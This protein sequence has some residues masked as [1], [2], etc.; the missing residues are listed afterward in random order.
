[1]RCVEGY[2]Y[3]GDVLW[4]RCAKKLPKWYDKGKKDGD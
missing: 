2:K 3:V 4:L 1:M